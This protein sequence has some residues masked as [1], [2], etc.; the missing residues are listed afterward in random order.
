MANEP[1]TTA[2]NPQAPDSNDEW[3]QLLPRLFQWARANLVK[4]GI[5][6]PGTA[7]EV[8]SRAFLTLKT[9]GNYDPS[10]G[11]LGPFL[12]KLVWT[13]VKEE[14]RKRHR[15]PG[16]YGA[17]FESNDVLL[18][19]EDSF[20]QGLSKLDTEW[21]QRQKDRTQLALQRIRER[22]RPMDWEVFRRLAVLPSNAAKV[23]A[24]QVAQE[25]NA[26]FHP[27]ELLDLAKVHRIVYKVRKVFNEEFQSVGIQPF[28]DGPNLSAICAEFGMVKGS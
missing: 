20:Q 12:W 3:E 11:P 26:E 7:D 18:E 27:A 23:T 4:V 10:K 19:L 6:D 15:R 8:V 1:V 24:A 17:G 14:Q 28:E 9:R 13:E 22:I 21:R 25:I 16:D 5:L 2:H